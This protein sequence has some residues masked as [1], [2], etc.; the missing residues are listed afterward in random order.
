V[1]YFHPPQSAVGVQT[2]RVRVTFRGGWLSEFYP[3]ADLAVPVLKMAGFNS[4]AC[5]RKRRA[6]SRGMI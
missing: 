1:I 2:A 3:A 4:G 6:S 5:W